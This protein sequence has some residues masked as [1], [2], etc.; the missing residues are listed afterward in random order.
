MSILLRER[1]S[2]AIVHNDP[3]QWRPFDPDVKIT[4]HRRGVC[5]SRLF[6]HADRDAERVDIP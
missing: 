6:G 4:L 2:S 5:E 3:G 1:E